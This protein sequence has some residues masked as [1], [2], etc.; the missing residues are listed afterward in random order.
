MDM[1]WLPS[2]AVRTDTISSGTRSSSLL[3]D[4]FMVNDWLHLG[5]LPQ[6]LSMLKKLCK[7]AMF[8]TV[9]W[10]LINGWRIKAWNT[11]PS[12]FCLFTCYEWEVFLKRIFLVFSFC[13]SKHAFFLFFSPLVTRICGPTNHACKERHSK[14]IFP[15]RFKNGRNT[16]APCKCS[17]HKQT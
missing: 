11:I 8:T 9:I 4:N 16:I 17:V 7:F 3:G 15:I 12:D 10:Q 2:L 1:C 5:T 14:F 6:G 13:S